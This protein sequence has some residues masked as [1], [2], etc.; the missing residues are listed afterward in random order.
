ME[1]AVQPMRRA[2]WSPSI[3]GVRS[4]VILSIKRLRRVNRRHSVVLRDSENGALTMNAHDAP[5]AAR[6]ENGQRRTLLR[7]SLPDGTVKS[8]NPKSSFISHDFLL[9]D[10]DCSIPSSSLPL[11]SSHSHGDTQP[12]L[13]TGRPFRCGHPSSAMPVLLRDWKS[14]I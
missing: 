11:D 3:P 5:C 14:P 2:W 13:R 9:A 4:S 12:S 7:Q 1:I 8:G 10:R 6:V